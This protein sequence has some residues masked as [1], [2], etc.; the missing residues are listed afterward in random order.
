M[1][2]YDMSVSK[3]DEVINV[4]QNDDLESFIIASSDTQRSYLARFYEH[5]PYSKQTHE[6]QITNHTCFFNFNIVLG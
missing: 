5:N 3:Y 6:I 2:E 4:Y 1:D